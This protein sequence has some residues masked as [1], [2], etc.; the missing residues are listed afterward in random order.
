M[1]DFR[2]YV[3]TISAIFLALAL[4]LLIGIAHGED[5]LVSSQRE[6]IELLERDLERQQYFLAE[7][8]QEI[9]RWESLKPVILAGYSG[10]LTGKEIL[11]IAGEK[12]SA[13]E[14]QDLLVKAG[15]ATV[16]LHLSG[17]AE[18][19]M[20]MPEVVQEALTGPEGP[21]WQAL[22]TNGF[23][24]SGDLLKTV[25]GYYILF[26]EQTR[27]PD[28]QFFY[29]LWKGLQQ[30]GFRV[31]AVSNWNDGE[32]IAVI[33]TDDYSL[34]DNIDTFWGQLALLEMIRHD[35]RGDYGFDPARIALLPLP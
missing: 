7:Q 22:E 18:E 13:A 29:L 10:S 24:R 8:E 16:L 35:Y 15:A 17:E 31:I 26:L 23:F 33:D 21:D 34:V 4:G 30:K 27:T 12:K 1:F 6:T 2:E 25:F 14:I 11:V 19:K 3:I 5:F 28:N 32:S 9:G 20:T